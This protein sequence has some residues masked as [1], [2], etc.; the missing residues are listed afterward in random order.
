MNAFAE[1]EILTYK[2]GL[3]RHFM[4]PRKKPF[5]ATHF[6]LSPHPF[7][8]LNGS[9]F[10]RQPLLKY[11]PLNCRD[12]SWLFV[13]RPAECRSIENSERPSMEEKEEKSW[14]K[15]KAAEKND[16]WRCSRRVN[17]MEIPIS[18]VW[19]LFC[20][21]VVVSATWCLLIIEATSRSLGY[22]SRVLSCN[23]VWAFWIVLIAFYHFSY[24][25]LH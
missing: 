22:S 13:C 16:R 4:I 6:I 14:V 23:Q 17:G 11:L 12:L 7:P 8:F 24:Q 10:K 1:R 25:W 20:N 2:S 9:L 3:K 15:G 18:C 5:W 19:K 21:R